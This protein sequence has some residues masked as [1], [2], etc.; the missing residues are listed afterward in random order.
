MTYWCHI[1]CI[2]IIIENFR[3]EEFL[4]YNETDLKQN[5]KISVTLFL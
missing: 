1:F 5:W 2:I 3:K 4:F